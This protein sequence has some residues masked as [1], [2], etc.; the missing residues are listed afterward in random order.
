MSKIKIYL[1]NFWKYLLLKVR[2]FD[3]QTVY[4]EGGLGS[5]ILSYIIYSERLKSKNVMV[6]VDIEYF[7]EVTSDFIEKDGLSKWSW[8]LKKYGVDISNFSENSKFKKK[9]KKYFFVRPLNSTYDFYNFRETKS[10][11]YIGKLP[12]DLENIKNYLEK[13]F[14]SPSNNFGIIH[15]RRGD[16]LK[17]ASSII[18][19]EEIVDLIL[20]IK[21]LMPKNI[22]IASDS[23]LEKPEI[24]LLNVTLT[25]FNYVFISP[26][27]SDLLIHDLMRYSK[28]LI[29]SNSTFSFTAGLLSSKDCLFFFPTKY[30]G[31]GK[32]QDSRAWLFRQPFGYLMN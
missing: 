25:E 7:R 10:L 22:L 19:V 30:F 3:K 8:K 4:F 23:L 11:E 13:T 18:K 26:N 6:P 9:I 31:E 20:K 17:V 32:I 2:M 24:E 29:A 15:I 27:E 28:V 12:I 1:F 5:Q 16:Y 21:N 14:S